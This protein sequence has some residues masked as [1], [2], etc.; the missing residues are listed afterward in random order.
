MRRLSVLILLIGSITTA[1]SKSSGDYR[2]A[3]EH[4]LVLAERDL[5]K[6]IASFPEDMK[7]TG[8]TLREQARASRDSD[9][10]TCVAK[11]EE[12]GIDT[13][14]VLGAETLDDAARCLRK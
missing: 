11:G 7:D 2:K 9:L 13:K 6:S 3:C 12:R 10:A 8:A 4:L 14:C 1:C 5:E